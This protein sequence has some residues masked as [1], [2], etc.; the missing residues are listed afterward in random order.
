MITLN[1]EPKQFIIKFILIVVLFLIVVGISTCT[2]DL[3][4]ELAELSREVSILKSQLS[5]KEQEELKDISSKIS[6]LSSRAVTTDVL[7]GDIDELRDRLDK[8]ESSND[9]LA[10][11]VSS[12]KDRLDKL[13]DNYTWFAVTEQSQIKIDID[14]NTKRIYSDMR[15]NKVEYY[16]KTSK[17]KIVEVGRKSQISAHDWDGGDTTFY[18]IVNVYSL[19]QYEQ[20]IIR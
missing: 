10:E 8:L 17:S 14:Y 9:V 1:K 16:F 3:E 19:Y 20:Y 15:D 6:K 13:G 7:Q 18:H 4:N 2:A 5:E 12:L 11:Q